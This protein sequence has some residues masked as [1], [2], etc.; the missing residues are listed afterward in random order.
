MSGKIVQSEA[1][2]ALDWAQLIELADEIVI[3]PHANIAPESITGHGR[4]LL[5]KALRRFAT[6][7]DIVEPT[8]PEATPEQ[9]AAT[10]RALDWMDAEADKWAAEVNLTGFI[11]N[12]VKVGQLGKNVPRAIRD[13]F[14][15]RQESLIDA[16]MRQCF[17]EGFDRGQEGRRIF[18]EWKRSQNQDHP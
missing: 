5:A 13:K 18:E 9:I 14:T 17:V 1:S 11:K 15:A 4:E 8:E 3:L 16:M 6:I 10:E 7:T 12:I 2:I